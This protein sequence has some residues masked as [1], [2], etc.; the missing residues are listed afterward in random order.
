[1]KNF[2]IPDF[3]APIIYAIMFVVLMLVIAMWITGCS[4]NINLNVPA[5]TVV[6]DT[7]KVIEGAWY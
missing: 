2:K 1:M 5:T 6:A 7:T 3:L 4:I